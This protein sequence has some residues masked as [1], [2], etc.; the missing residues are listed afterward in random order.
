MN[1]WIYVMFGEAMV[2][3]GRRGREAGGLEETGLT[4][5][6][7]AGRVEQKRES[8]VECTRQLREG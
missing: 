6:R 4:T 8:S 3:R 2:E 5:R 7:Q 1:Y